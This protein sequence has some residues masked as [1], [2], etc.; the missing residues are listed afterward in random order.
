MAK[1]A[2]ILTGNQMIKR[3]ILL[4]L[5]LFPIGARALGLN[6]V[7]V[8]SFLNEKL[9]ARIELVS[10]S[11]GMIDDIRVALANP[12]AFKAMGVDRPFLLSK[13]RFKVQ[14]GTDQ[15]P[16]I[17]ISSKGSIREPFLDFL[18]EVNWP[19][20]NL[21]R[22][23]SLLLD[24]RTYKPTLS[25]APVRSSAVS[26]PAAGQP[27]ASAPTSQSRS[28]GP[29]RS[30]DTLWVIARNT[31]PDSSVTIQQMMMALQRSNPGAFSQGNVNL[32]RKGAVLAIPGRDII[33]AMTPQ[34]AREVFREQTRQWKAMRE[35]GQRDASSA[36]ARA[37]P[38]T[39]PPGGESTAQ[40]PETPPGQIDDRQPDAAGD[41]AEPP[42]GDQVQPE[43]RQLRVVE[44]KQDY[45][46]GE[47][48]S[49]TETSPGD[50]RLKQAIVNSKDDLKA[51]KEINQ[52]LDELR[53]V[54]ETKV[55]A[56]R[57]SLEDK[58]Q[59][60]EE[61]QKELKRPA[62]ADKSTG[63]GGKSVVAPDR[64]GAPA[65]VV[66]EVEPTAQ[67]EKVQP[68]VEE[69]EPAEPE[70]WIKQY[71]RHLA[72]AGLSI[73]LVLIL[74][75]LGRAK[76]RAARY[77]EED[78]QFP[79]AYI[80]LDDS[81]E[82]EPE[83]EPEAETPRVSSR[84][85]ADNLF[86]APDEPKDQRVHEGDEGLFHE[87][88]V[89]ISGALSEADVYLA[90]HRYGRAESLIKDAINV[91][92]D[93][94]MLKAK[95]LEIYAFR[96]DKKQFTSYMEQMYESADDASPE[97]WARIVEMGRDLI[98]DHPLIGNADLPGDADGDK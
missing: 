11:P 31:R 85:P 89:D 2:R 32:L 60:V 45:L 1:P 88:S 52:D 7:I 95:L 29:V 16:Y 58:N 84:L 92:P 74:V 90:Y 34:E 91:N 51:V 50:K 70:S 72:L 83:P 5:L 94:M 61:L 13:L 35:G 6:D 48:D 8:N 40:S 37:E 47:K 43:D 26:S 62:V 97:L 22:Q 21:V 18:I 69:E 17:Q 68:L 30:T 54:L 87:Q 42:V 49:A 12:D 36:V 79:D 63:G 23:Y 64:K 20:G 4:T 9:D 56:L 55:E 86:D 73:V 82:P 59:A 57:K 46:A 38:E 14:S 53:A 93:S 44:T 80:E 65:D 15:R 39:A 41:A 25:A 33:E 78:T 96:R 76:R 77:S 28:Y 24:P 19:G 75:A 3:T 71:W 10:A 98:P 66:T 81:P 27:R 67:P